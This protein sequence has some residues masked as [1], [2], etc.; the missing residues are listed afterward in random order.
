M[1]P[2]VGLRTSRARGEIFHDDSVTTEVYGI[3]VLPMLEEVIA[4]EKVTR[5]G[6]QTLASKQW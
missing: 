2:I 6:S 5:C 1:S 3:T 4:V